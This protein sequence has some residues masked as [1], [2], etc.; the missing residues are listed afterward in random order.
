MRGRVV[1]FPALPA[2]DRFRRG[3]PALTFG[4]APW[5]GSHAKNNVHDAFDFTETLRAEGE[6][7]LDVFVVLPGDLEGEACGCELN[8]PQTIVA[9]VSIVIKGLDVG[10]AP[11]IVL[12]LT[13]NEKVGLI[14]RRKIQLIVAG[15]LVIERDLEILAAGLSDRHMFG[16]ESHSRRPWFSAFPSLNQ[17]QEGQK[18]YLTGNG[19]VIR[20]A[21][22]AGPVESPRT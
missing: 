3:G 2:A 19:F 20:I 7:D 4:E 18:G 22:A 14:R 12:E 1:C 9:G 10:D 15:V 6:G 16:V 11:I 5:S 21:G 17:L 8:E 13:L